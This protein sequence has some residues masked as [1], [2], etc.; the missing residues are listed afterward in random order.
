MQ[1]V[2]SLKQRSWASF[3]L[4]GP[5]SLAGSGPAGLR[6]TVRGAESHGA[7]EASRRQLGA[8]VANDRRLGF[9]TTEVFFCS[10]TA[11]GLCSLHRLKGRVLPPYASVF[12]GVPHPKSLLVP[13]CY[14]GHCQFDS[15]LKC[16]CKDTICKKSP[17]PRFWV[18]MA[19]WGPHRS[20]QYRHS[21][22]NSTLKSGKKARGGLLVRVAQLSQLSRAPV[23]PSDTHC[24]LG[25]GSWLPSTDGGLSEWPR[26]HS[27]PELGL[28]DGSA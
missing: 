21:I 1:A 14:K 3:L 7:A 9:H 15:Y 13:S 27:W 10:G 23:S 16:I 4:E 28:E 12:R 17:I 6:F 5:T 19:F 22:A 26:S 25:V 11:A 2:C 20:G 18:D 24:W 8:A